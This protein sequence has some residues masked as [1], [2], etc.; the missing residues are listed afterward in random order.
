MGTNVYPGRARIDPD[1]PETIGLCDRCGSLWNLRDL[2]YQY[3]WSGPNLQNTFLLVCEDCMDVP[4]ENLRTII[5]PPDP[6]PVYNVRVPNF[7][8][9]EKNEYGLSAAGIG[10]PLFQASSSMLAE[11][12]V[13]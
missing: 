1:A 5:L 2:Q 4:N 7:A 12:T 3:K 9:M 8:I 11:L 13:A 10:T 6:A